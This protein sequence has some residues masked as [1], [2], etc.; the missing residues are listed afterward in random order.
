MMLKM[1]ESSAF[2]VRRSGSPGKLG[3]D[4]EHL[5]PNLRACLWRRSLCL[6]GLVGALGGLLLEDA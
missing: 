3:V 6:G 1:P 2:P 5:P 4:L